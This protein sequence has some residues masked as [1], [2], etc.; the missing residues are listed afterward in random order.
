MLSKSNAS[1]L[2]GRTED[3]LLVAAADMFQWI[4]APS[5]P[6]LWRDALDFLL[7][8]RTK[9][10]LGLKEEDEC[11]V[12]GLG[13]LPDRVLRRFLRAPAVAALL[14]GRQEDGTR[15]DGRFNGRRFSE[16]LLSEL[17]VEGILAELPA[18]NW[19]PRGDCFLDCCRDSKEWKGKKGNL[20]GTE[21]AVDWC[22]PF[23]FPDEK[24]PCQAAFYDASECVAVEK[25]LLASLDMLRDLCERAWDLVTTVV[26][27]IA[28][29]RTRT[30]ENNLG[31]FYSS[32]FW[33]YP[34]LVRFTNPLLPEGD[35]FAM[36]EAMV[37]EAIHCL[38]H[39]Y[40]ELD[41]PFIQ[42]GG[43]EH[44]PI[45]SPWTGAT[46]RLHSYIHACAVWYGIYWFW[47]KIEALGA[48]DFERIR[49]LKERARRGFQALPVSV[50]L[51]PF[52]HLI[53]D[54]AKSLLRDLEGRMVTLA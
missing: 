35:V 8:R 54:P 11:L 7:L 32:T 33:G 10:L 25:K 34:G 12:Q 27:V 23:P 22:S 44:T 49:P 28:L 37:H 39:I 43:T 13:L 26:E 47:S 38:L 24:E 46:I 21:I 16:L 14:L 50:G 15:P 41:A 2:D 19:T 42:M 17:A 53:S 4:S 52:E 5:S 45:V 9:Q 6:I 40:E 18:S 1:V 29:R 36:A 20:H 48:Y 3:P 30:V 51:G 31:T